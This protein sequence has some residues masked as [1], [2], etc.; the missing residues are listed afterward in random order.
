LN[1]AN[2]FTI[3]QAPEGIGS[4]QTILRTPEGCIG[5]HGS[6]H[7]I[8]PT[9]E[10]RIGSVQTKAVL[11]AFKPFRGH[12]KAVLEA[13]ETFIKPFRGTRRLCTDFGCPRNGLKASNASIQILAVRG[14]V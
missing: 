4:V 9:A 11:E 7:T 13:F 10:I 8:P 5:S 2:L 12:P 14:M 6:F 3:S 1:L